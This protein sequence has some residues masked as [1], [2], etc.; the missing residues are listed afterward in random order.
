[1]QD[2]LFAFL[3]VCWYN[4]VAAPTL[5]EPAEVNASDSTIGM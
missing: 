5:H 3:V 1:M 4:R 2:T